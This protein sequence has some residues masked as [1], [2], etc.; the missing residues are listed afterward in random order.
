MKTNLRNINNLKNQKGLTIVELMVDLVLS[1]FVIGIL[2]NLYSNYKKSY[3]IHFDEALINQNAHAVYKYLKNDLQL[4]GFFGCDSSSE[5][6]EYAIPAT[7]DYSLATS[8]S[9]YEAT[10]TGL[11]STINLTSPSTNWSPAF[12]GQISNV[13]PNSGSDILTIR[14]AN[15]NPSAVLQ[16]L[17]NGSSITTTAAATNIAQNDILLVSDCIRTVVFQVANISGTTITPTQSIGTINALGEIY[18]INVHSYYIKTV[19]NIPTLYRLSNNV[20]E[21][22][23]PNI[24]NMQIMYG[25]DTNN[26]GITDKFNLANNLQD[27]KITSLEV[28]VLI[29]SN[30]KHNQFSFPNTY[31]LLGSGAPFNT[32]ITINTQNDKYFRKTFDFSLALPNAISS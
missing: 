4:S 26:D 15:T 28:G 27:Y 31:E 11:N 24:E 20:E 29:K 13:S 14:Y 22:L 32:T 16:T 6:I 3:N 7:F 23:V 17:S 8:I 1:V 10:S 2:V 25:Q 9:A 18:K 30:N 12:N 19:D 5:N 21:A